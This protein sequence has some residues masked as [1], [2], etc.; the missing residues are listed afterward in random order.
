VTRVR[1]QITTVRRDEAAL[2]ARCA[3]L[4]WRVQVTNLPKTRLNLWDCVQAYNQG[5]SLERD[6]HVLKDR[7]L[8]IQPLYVREE[9]QIDGLTR[10]LMIGLRVLTL[11][12]GVVRARLEKNKEELSGLYTGQ[13][14]RKTSRP[15]AVRLLRAIARMEIAAL[16]AVACDT[17][18]WHLSPLP[19]LLLKILELAG[20]PATLYTKLAI[21]SSG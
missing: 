7:P 6:F 15:T 9:E 13:A 16:R 20:L 4:G 11:F 10:L 12:E 14:K 18:E 1:Y 8:G 19:P 2:Q 5:W 21:V 3:R 17:E